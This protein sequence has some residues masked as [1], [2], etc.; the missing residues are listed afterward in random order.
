MGATPRPHTLPHS[1]TAPC[2]PYP[3]PMVYPYPM[4]IPMVVPQPCTAT[5]HTPH[6]EPQRDH[7]RHT[8]SHGHV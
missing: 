5:T 8:A 7:E 4:P 1:L 2:Y 3:I 6:T